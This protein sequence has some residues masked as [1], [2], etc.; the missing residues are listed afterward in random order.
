LPV[1]NYGEKTGS[2]KKAAREGRFANP[3]GG[4]QKVEV[5]GAGRRGEK[6]KDAP[7]SMRMV[8]IVWG[9]GSWGKGGKVWGRR[10]RKESVPCVRAVHK[11]AEEDNFSTL[12]Y[13]R[14]GGE[15]NNQMRVL[16]KKKSNW[17]RAR[18]TKKNH[19]KNTKKKEEKKT[20]S[21]GLCFYT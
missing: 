17:E 5:K 3:G 13:F 16:T 10:A 21:E 14:T 8:K 12:Q 4:A 11:L 19:K 15:V 6:G 1:V 2:K 7:A 9:G 20:K 18:R